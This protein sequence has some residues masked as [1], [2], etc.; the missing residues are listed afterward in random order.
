MRE[1]DIAYSIYAG[2]TG[3]GDEIGVKIRGVRL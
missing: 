2:L 1:R 3:D